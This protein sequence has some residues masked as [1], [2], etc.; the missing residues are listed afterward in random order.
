MAKKLKYDERFAPAQATIPV[1]P[2]C[3]AHN[4]SIVIGYDTIL[5]KAV[6]AAKMNIDVKRIINIITEGPSDVPS[7]DEDDE[8]FLKFMACL[9][10]FAK[11]C[12][13]YGSKYFYCV[14]YKDRLVYDVSHVGDLDHPEPDRMW[15]VDYISPSLVNKKI[16]ARREPVADML[17]DFSNIPRSGPETF[18][19]EDIDELYNFFEEDAEGSI[20]PD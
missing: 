8:V 13:E 4:A 20:T 6:W 10:D 2:F 5:N 16:L 11:A 7:K 3:W 12:S 9:D 15:K 18:A 1:A 17:K 14:T 19:A